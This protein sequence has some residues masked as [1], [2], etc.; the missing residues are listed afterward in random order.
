M[1]NIIHAVLRYIKCIGRQISA[2]IFRKIVCFNEKKPGYCSVNF[3]ECF[4]YLPLPQNLLSP[5]RVHSAFLT[6]GH[7]MHKLH[8]K[9]CS[10]INCWKR[11]FLVFA[12]VT[13]N[14]DG[15]EKTGTTLCGS[16][17]PYFPLCWLKAFFWQRKKNLQNHLIT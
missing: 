6:N 1:K 7:F 14:E 17:S 10:I 8:N 9:I 3:S 12:L 2:N 4:I 5:N 16:R 11:N 13:A 15:W